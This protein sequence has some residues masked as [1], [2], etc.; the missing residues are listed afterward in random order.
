MKNKRAAKA[1]TRSPSAAHVIAGFRYQLL[2]SVSALLGLR[3]DEE[4]LLEIS[5]DFTIVAG[6]AATDVQVKNS[7]ATKGPRPFSLQ[8]PEVAAVLGRYWDLSREGTINRRLVFLARGGAAIER[9]F[10]FPGNLSGLAYW[11]AAAMDSD[12]QPLRAALSAILAGT[13]L[14]EWVA[15]GPSDAELRSR[16]LHRV[17]WELESI[18]AEQLTT[19]LRDQIGELFYARNLPI[20]AASQALKSLMDL[21]FETAAKPRAQDRRLTQFDL[22]KAMEEAAAAI[23]LGQQ[24]APS[25]QASEGIGQSVLVSELGGVWPF[26]AQRAGIIDNLLRATSGQPLIWIHGANGVGKSTLARLVGQRIGGRWLEL[27]LRPVQKDA[28]GSTAAWRELTRMIA[29]TAPADGIIVDDFDDDASRALRSRLTALARLLGSRGAR[30]V[31]TS[32]RVPSPALLLECGT[33]TTASIQ[34]PYFSEADV[35][36]L[37][38]AAP[39]PAK[40]MIA[41]WSI[42]IRLSTRGGHPLL[43]AAKVSSLRARGWPDTALV[44]D[45]I[46]EPSDAIKLSRDEAR[47]ALLEDLS[48][49]DQ[50]RSLD[51]GSLLRRIACVF[52]RVEDGLIR[53]LALAGPSLLNGG[54]ALAVLR[55]T[56]LEAMPGGDELCCNLGDEAD[57]AALCGFSSMTSIPSWNVAPAMSLGN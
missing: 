21:A 15:A 1:A 53:Q 25:L 33:S 47:R 54:D 2:Q 51:A 20:I 57:Q 18:S 56:W 14:G 4:L 19:Q 45:I 31:V 17:Q 32:H 46:G 22:V 34:A 11:R 41:P 24:M 42:F 48:E 50:A 12:T 10:D 49:L 13:P 40:D 26:T 36:E 6:Y 38:S 5:E 44:E 43:A 37:V 23:L 28:A 52:D 30:L 16:L 7:Q 8:S 55:G 9:G 35:V 29:L 3:G 39:S 27:D